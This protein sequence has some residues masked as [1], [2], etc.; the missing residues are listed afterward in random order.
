MSCLLIT[1]IL[2]WDRTTLCLNHH[3]N[4]IWYTFNRMISLL[5]YKFFLQMKNYIPHRFNRNNVA[6]LRWNSMLHVCPNILYRVEIGWVWRVLMAPHFQLL[7][8]RNIYLFMHRYIVFQNNRLNYISNW[9]FS[10]VFEWPQQDLISINSGINLLS[11]FKIKKGTRSHLT[12]FKC[13]PKQYSSSSFMLFVVNTI[14]V[15]SFISFSPNLVLCTV[16]HTNFDSYLISPDI[17]FSI[18]NSQIDIPLSKL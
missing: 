15:K 2:I 8:D 9:F 5:I 7:S 4:S 18:L 11:I 10:E 1:L 14:R 17:C 6:I 12:L 13:P 3:L 16:L